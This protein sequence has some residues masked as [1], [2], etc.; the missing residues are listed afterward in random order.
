M[1]IPRNAGQSG[2][3]SIVSGTIPIYAT[4]T[5]DIYFFDSAGAAMNISGLGFYFQFRKDGTNTGADITL[6]T[7]TGELSIVADGGSVNSILRINANDGVFSAWAGDMIADLLAVDGSDNVT[8]YSH[9]V[10]SFT[11]N[12]VAV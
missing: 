11:N 5:E 10:I 3:E 12:P 8:L 2:A 1:T 4:W 6:S 7:V 9:G